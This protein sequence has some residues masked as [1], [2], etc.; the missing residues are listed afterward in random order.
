MDRNLHVVDVGNDEKAMIFCPHRA[1]LL[2]IDGTMGPPDVTQ[3]TTYRND[4]CSID[5]FLHPM[6]R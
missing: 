2:C 4:C 5:E 3:N 1:S 6:R